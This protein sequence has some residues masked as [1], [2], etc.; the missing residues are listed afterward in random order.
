MVNKN[1]KK[2]VI[3]SLCSVAM[4]LLISTILII[5]LSADRRCSY[6]VIVND[7]NVNFEADVDVLK[8]FDHSD[9]RSYAVTGGG[10]NDIG[11]QYIATVS[12]SLPLSKLRE[13]EEYLGDEYEPGLY[14]TY[15]QL[16]RFYETEDYDLYIFNNDLVSG[17]KK[18]TVFWG[19]GGKF[20]S[21]QIPFTND[22]SMMIGAQASRDAIYLYLSIKA[23]DGSS[24]GRRIVRIDLDGKVEQ[25]DI[26]H[27]ELF[28]R[29]N[30]PLYDNGMFFVNGRLY[31]CCTGQ[32]TSIIYSY[33]PEIGETGKCELKG[34]MYKIF[35]ENDEII[36]L[37][38]SGNIYDGMTD[39][40]LCLQKFNMDLTPKETVKVNAPEGYEILFPDVNG[41]YSIYSSGKIFCLMS[42]DCMPD[43]YFTVID[44][45]SG[46]IEYLAQFVPYSDSTKG[47]Y[48]RS[49]TL[50]VDGKP[51]YMLSEYA[52]K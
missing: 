9:I 34:R 21:A 4:A 31:F 33:D 11:T 5:V 37:C 24:V 50:K 19:R 41:Q 14:E 51:V 29:K 6:N 17:D 2:I 20:K 46:D 39:S 42:I 10:I 26:S 12:H 23:D 8:L 1:S 48:V 43:G 49:F 3:I 7:C 36:A 30:L 40:G 27:K 52:D 38:D 47:Y 45:D 32:G 35:V 13:I 28:G 16:I 18:W 15:G 22:L 44:A 25:T